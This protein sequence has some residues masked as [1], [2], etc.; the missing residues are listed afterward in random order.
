MRAAPAKVGAPSIVADG[1]LRPAWAEIDLDA[2]RHNAEVL[3]RRAAP[4]GLCAVVKAGGYGHGAVPVAR[5]ALD[6]GASHLAVALVEEGRQLREAGITAPVIVLSQPAPVAMAEVVASG[7]IPTLYTPA[8]VDALVEAVRAHGRRRPLPVH[9]KVDTGMH[10]VGA[11]PEEAVTIATAVASRPELDLEGVFTHLAVADELDQPFTD[12]QLARFDQVLA[13]LAAAG[14]RPRLRHAANSAGMLFHPN[15]RY[16][17]VRCGIALY[18]LAPAADEVAEAIAADL[19]PAM[20]LKT[21][22]VHVKEVEAGERLSYGLRYRVPV[23]SVVATI[24]V[25][26]ADGVTRSLSAAG[27]VALIGGHRHRLAGTVTMDQTLVDCGPGADISVGD[28]VVLLGRQGAEEITAWE[29][30]E[31]TGTIAYEVVCG[32]SGRVPRVYPS[33]GPPAVGAADVPST[34]R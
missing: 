27:G 3:G 29:W 2:I 17:L 10:R 13:D 32:V 24:P 20:T 19:R 34:Y 25:G 26:Y 11:A 1:R 28:E 30:A 31:R 15:A 6:G 22:V 23:R 33:D 9:V 4:A 12:L 5:A 8:G 7:L 18:G 21:R 16:D 14:I